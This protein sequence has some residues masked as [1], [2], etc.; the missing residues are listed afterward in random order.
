MIITLVMFFVLI[1]LYLGM[2][3]LVKFSEN[4]IALPQPAPL[5]DGAEKKARDGAQPL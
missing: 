4:V 1:A 2:L 3:G 5:A